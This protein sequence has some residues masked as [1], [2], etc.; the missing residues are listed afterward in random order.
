MVKDWKRNF[1][2]HA[3][4]VKKLSKDSTKRKLDERD[5]EDP[6]QYFL[7]RREEKKWSVKDS[8]V[9]GQGRET[10]TS[11]KRISVGSK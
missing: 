10:E 11:G 4:K 6:S 1:W 7:Y 2:N 8:E 3:Q 9:K 5:P